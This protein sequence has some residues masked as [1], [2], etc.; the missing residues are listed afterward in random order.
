[1]WDQGNAT[2]LS[3]VHAKWN[4]KGAHEF[5]PS[6]TGQS[7]RGYGMSKRRQQG[8]D[9]MGSLAAANWGNATALQMQGG[10]TA[11]G[12][13]ALGTEAQWG[14]N[15]SMGQGA[16]Y[17]TVG[18]GPAVSSGLK[19]MTSQ[20]AAAASTL[21]L[22]WNLDN[23][24]KQK[25]IINELAKIDFSV[26]R[27]VEVLEGSG[28]FLLL[29]AEVWHAK[30]LVVSLDGTQEHL[31]TQQDQ[32]IRLAVIDPEKMK[33]SAEDIPGPLMQAFEKLTHNKVPGFLTS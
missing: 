8:Q 24:Y 7:N 6:L 30:A 9:M 15:G 12:G 20:T 33:W 4:E 25:D 11:M 22:A 19:G 26:E 29:F 14:M 2:Q 13:A 21:V 5:I 1:M 31:K 16:S 17:L 3:D 10:W 18:Q 28:S 23:A 32:E 27:C